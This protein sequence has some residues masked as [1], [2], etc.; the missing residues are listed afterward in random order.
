[1][2]DNNFDIVI[3]GAG[4]GGYVAAIKAAQLGYK[5]ACIE[6]DNPGGVC[7]NWGCIPT[8]ALLESAAMITHLGHAAEFGVTVGEIKTDMAQAVKRSRQVSERLTKGVGFL[9]KKN[10]VTH[11]PGR[12]RLAGKGKVEVTPKDG[13]AKQTVTAKHVIIAT[14]SKPRDLPFLKIDHERVWDSTDAMLA[15][16]AP[17]TLAVV[18]AGAIGCEFADVYAAFGTKVTIIEMADRILPLEDRDCS[19]VVEKSYKKR[20]MQILTSVKL[21]KAEVGAGGVKLSITDAKGQTQVIEAERV[22]SAIGR[23]PLTADLGLESAGVKLT[24]RG[25]IGVDRQMRTNVEGIYAIG[26]VAGPPLLAH[27]GS[28][29]GVACIEG[30]H[31]DPHAGIDY[32][33]IPN[34]TYCHPEV[35]SIGL[36]EEQARAQGIDIQVGVFPWTANGRAL[37]AGETDGFVKVIRDTKYSELVGAHIV[38]PHATELIAEFVVGRHLETTVEEMD[39]AMHPHPTL[40]EAIGEAALA[41]LGHALHI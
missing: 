28:H 18:G 23:V 26:D 6:E 11:L 16:E 27:K 14:G 34:C 36:T 40:S 19:A 12:G 15:K 5:V 8:K 1:M 7:L 31:G 24:D 37:T 25:F 4:P 3:I 20:G 2:A 41:A 33:N 9:F 30:I 29:E 32:N 39:R 13:G 38:G 35:A 22:L 21:D 17:K 10:K